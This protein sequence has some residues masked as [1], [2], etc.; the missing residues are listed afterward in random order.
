M[1]RDRDVVAL[2]AGDD[3][4]VPVH[5]DEPVEEL[6][7]RAHLGAVGGERERRLAAPGQ[8]RFGQADLVTD[9]HVGL[10]G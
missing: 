2:R 4:N 1:D 7:E 3:R 10:R 8:C 9:G 6:V 5:D